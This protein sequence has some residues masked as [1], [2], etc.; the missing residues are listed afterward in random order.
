MMPDC[1][2]AYGNVAT[3]VPIIVFQ[4]EKMIMIEPC[5]SPSYGADTAKKEVVNHLIMIFF[6]L[7]YLLNGSLNKNRS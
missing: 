7:I 4:H 5:F 2:N 6:N 1:W 3:A